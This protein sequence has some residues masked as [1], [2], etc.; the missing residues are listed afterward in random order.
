MKAVPEEISVHALTTGDK[1]EQFLS[2]NARDADA[3]QLVTSCLEQIGPIPPNVNLGFVYLTDQLAD[4]V[5]QV[6]GRLRQLAPNITWIGTVGMG[7]CAGAEEVYDSPAI[8]MLL[9]DFPTDSFYLL[10]DFKGDSAALESGLSAWCQAQD[11]CFSLF[12]GDPSN[13]MTPAWIGSLAS[14]PGHC[15]V[16]G[17]LTSSQGQNPQIAN[18][19]VTGGLSGIVFNQQVEVATDHTQGCSPIGPVHQIT[20]AEQNIAVTLDDRPALEVM[21]E[22]IGEVLSKRLSQIGG[23]V[24]AALPIRGVDTNDYLV[25]NLVGIDPNQG[26]VAVGDSLEEQQQLMFCRR[27]GNTARDDMERMLERLKSRLQGTT[28]RGGI[29]ISCLGRGRNQF[30]ADSE[31]LKLIRGSLGTFPLVGFFANGE[32]YNGR[33]YGYT[34]VL[35]LFL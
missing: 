16:N 29:Y 23:Y 19:M 21:K 11:S 27:D 5:E 1:M 3:G 14:I 8:S 33:L 30:G 26:L 18:E 35:T 9:C 22:D 17:G 13:P 2:A 24:F 15:F 25:R 34:G 12:H 10:P 20:R 4:S 28:I 7:I 32:I 31:E 6:I